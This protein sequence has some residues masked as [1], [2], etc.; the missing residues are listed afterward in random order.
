MNWKKVSF[1]YL[2]LLLAICE[3]PIMFR[4]HDEVSEYIFSR[5]LIL[6]NRCLI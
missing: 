2:F 6:I 4:L 5:P 1:L 3:I